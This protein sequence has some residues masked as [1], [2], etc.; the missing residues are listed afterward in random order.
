MKDKL[1]NYSFWVGLVACIMLVVKLLAENFGFKINEEDINNIVN[2]VLGLLVI[3]GVINNP[4]SKNTST[5]DES[6]S[7]EEN[8]KESQDSTDDDNV[9]KD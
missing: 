4:T 1:K 7:T 5:V 6:L 8:E 9:S 3:L 2:S